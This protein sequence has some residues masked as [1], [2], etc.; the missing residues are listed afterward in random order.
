MFEEYVARDSEFTL[1]LS[2]LPCTDISEGGPVELRFGGELSVM[3]DIPARHFRL[4]HLMVKASLHDEAER[5]PERFR[6]F[7]STQALARGYAEQVGHKIPP[8]D[9]SVIAYVSELRKKVAAGLVLLSQEIALPDVSKFDPIEHHP[10]YGYRVGGI[11][12]RTLDYRSTS[13]LESSM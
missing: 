11:S 1:E 10:G 8:E 5:V 9:A 13:V 12:V 3:L 4:F 7:R 2:I 6:G